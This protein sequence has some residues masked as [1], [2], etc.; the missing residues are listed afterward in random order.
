[1]TLYLAFEGRCCCIAGE[2]NIFLPD[3]LVGFSNNE[4]IDCL[5]QVFDNSLD[6]QVEDEVLGSSSSKVN[7]AGEDDVEE[8]LAVNCKEK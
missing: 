8:G 5:T 4:S 6:K 1:M 7:I 3:S 2:L